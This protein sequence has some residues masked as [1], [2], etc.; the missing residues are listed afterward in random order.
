VGSSKDYKKDQDRL[1]VRADDAVG[2]L[3]RFAPDACNLNEGVGRGWKLVADQLGHSLDFSQNVYK[4]I[5]RK[6]LAG[7]PGRASG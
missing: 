7:L 5:C 2:K 6:N 1:S 3:P 4:Q